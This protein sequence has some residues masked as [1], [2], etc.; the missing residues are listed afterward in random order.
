MLL[1]L[2][3]ALIGSALTSH[4]KPIE[5]RRVSLDGYRIDV[6]VPPEEDPHLGSLIALF[7]RVRE[8]DEPDQF[9]SGTVWAR[10]GKVSRI[11]GEILESRTVRLR[12]FLVGE[13]TDEEKEIRFEFE[14]LRASPKPIN[15]RMAFGQ[16]T[17]VQRQIRGLDDHPLA[18]GKSGTLWSSMSECSFWNSPWGT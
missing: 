11:D 16:P 6:I 4:A 10:I 17:A 8:G 15:H 5:V 2:A 3:A 9:L 12:V 13:E 18:K 14:P 1:L 7:Y